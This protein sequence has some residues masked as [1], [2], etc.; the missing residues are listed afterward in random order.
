MSRARSEAGFTLVELLAAV[1]ILGVVILPL[2]GG[3]ILGLRTMDQTSHRY[4]GSNDAQ[5]LTRYLPPDVQSA[6]T[7]A[8][9]SLPACAGTSNRK[10][11]LTSNA[12]GTTG[13]RTTMYWL[14][15]PIAGRFELVRSVWANGAACTSGPAARTTVMAR[16]IANASH[17]V[18]TQLSGT[19]LGFKIS[20]TEAPAQNE[21]TG[22]TFAVTGR[23]RSS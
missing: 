12:Q 21:S 2:T 14:R 7:G 3:I 23:K 1:A 16:D 6:N 22:Y 4:A 13:S 8:V 11:L 9:S 19:P 18:S 5:V 20:V 10:L 15:G 17:V